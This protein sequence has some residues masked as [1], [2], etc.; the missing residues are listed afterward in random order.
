M[1]A[2]L[3]LEFGNNHFHKDRDAAK[4]CYQGSLQIYRDLGDTWGMAKALAR[5]GFLAHHVG[6]FEEAVRRYK[7]CLDLFRQLGDPR[8]IANALIGLGQNS[9]RL[10]QVEKGETYY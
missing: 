5:L 9:L 7:A 10:G 3:S 2:F 6:N 4:I 8:S 1:G